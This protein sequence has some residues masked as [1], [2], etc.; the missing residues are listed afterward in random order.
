M[1][2]ST[3]FNGGNYDRLGGEFSPKMNGKSEES[4]ALREWRRQNAVRLAEKE[5]REKEMV[6]LIVA[7]AD[8]YKVDFHRRRQLSSDARKAINRDKQKLFVETQ[9]MFHG[10]AHKN[11]WRAIAELI[12]NEVPAIETRGKKEKDKE[13]KLSILVIQ[14]SKPGKPTELSRMRQLFRKLKHNPPPHM[15]PP[16]PTKPNLAA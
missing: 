1:A 6:R 11:Y 13:K 8:E 2:S 16:P 10:E 3:L 5:K 14:G 9:E 15:N 4:F 7:E 12:P